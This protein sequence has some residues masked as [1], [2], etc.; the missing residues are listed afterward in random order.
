MFSTAG[1]PQTDG[2]TKVTNRT[3]GVLL[4]TLIKRNLKEWEDCLPIAEFT[5]NHT[6]HTT[7][8]FSHFEVVYGFNPLMPLDLVPLLSNEQ[9]NLDGEAK[10]RFV[11]D[12]HEKVRLQILKKNEHYARIVNKGRKAIVFEPGN[13]VWVHMR[14][15]RFPSSRRTKLHPRG[16]GPFQ[17]KA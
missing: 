10:A 9:L 5:Y 6:I 17:V 16:D 3:L 13:W 7:T 15:E 2:Q 4:R 14:K 11:Q 1:H 12:L 8:D